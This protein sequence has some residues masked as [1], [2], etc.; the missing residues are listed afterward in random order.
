MALEDRYEFLETIG[1]GTF[2]T[3]YRARDLELGREVAVK[4]LHEQY[5][6]DPAALERYWQEAQLLASLQHPNIVTIY[7]IHRERGWLI[8]ELM[9]SSLAKRMEGRQMDLRAVRTTLAHCLR[10]LKYL[11]PRGIVHGDIKLGNL[12]IDH[13][14]RVKLGDFG[15]AYRVSDDDGSILKGTTRYMAPEVVSEEF[16]EIG[17]ASDL[18]SLGFCAWEL[19]CGPNFES[20]FPG[21]SAFGRNRQ[22]AWMMWHAAPDRRLPEIHRVLEGVPEDVATVVQKLCEKD[23]SRRYSSADDALS[24]LNIDLKVVRDGSDEEPAETDSDEEAARRKRLWLAGGGFAASFLLS[25]VLLLLPAGGDPGPPTDSNIR[26]GTVQAVYADENRL[27]VG[28]LEDGIPE[29][30]DLGQR[31][32]IFFRNTQEHILIRELQPGDRVEIDLTRDENGN[33]QVAGVT[34]SR[35][36]TSL[37]RIR[38]VDLDNE[39]ILVAVEQGETRDDLSLRVPD[40]AALHLNE[41][42]RRVPLRDL[43]EGDSVQVT[44]LHEAGGRA[45]RVVQELTVNRL[46]ERVGLV[47]EIDAG[48]RRMTVRFG[49]QTT[50]TALSLPVAA[51][52]EITLRDAGGD[53]GQRIEL[54]AIRPGDRVQFSS[55]TEFHRIVAIRDQRQISGMVE[56]VDS[57]KR[58]LLIREA[59]GRES[60]FRLAE[61]TERRGDVTLGDDTIGLADLRQYDT[62]HLTAGDGEPALVSSL[63]ATRPAR[64]DRWVILIANDQFAEK[65]VPPVPRAVE[66]ANALH[67]VL[68]GRY[69]VSESRLLYLKNRSRAEIQRAVS[70]L[71]ERVGRQTQLVVYVASPGYVDEEGHAFLAT[72]DFN[73]NRM[74]ETGLPLDWLAGEIGRADTPD[75]LLLLDACF[76][77]NS[78]DR[79]HQPSTAEMLSGLSSPLQA[80]VAIASCRQGERGLTTLQGRRGVF[81]RALE[82]GFSGPADTNRD[83]RMTGDELMTWL[84]EEMPRQAGDRQQLP[85]RFPRK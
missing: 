21:L 13:R 38:A 27:K 6:S 20:L 51:D 61:Q 44:H 67:D 57:G 79:Q 3:V 83:L 11:H 16:G 81:S 77:G 33:R 42:G 23:Q 2:A 76:D 53:S 68:R 1:S 35:P 72:R 28:G 52:A 17:P 30:F 80:T 55:D 73:W 48:R 58:E 37:G 60:L 4:Q 24:D 22:I 18:Y 78:P 47:R 36:V 7:D 65:F 15:L 40:S 75:R 14:R 5:L 32:K 45:G 10:A 70:E 26:Y 39:R 43:R 56:Q 82:A 31:P 12:M 71:V 84:R 46:I 62:V 34:V 54:N 64:A 59:N 85:E 29:E 8:M 69:A 9:Q 50:G 74:T 19:M 49:P 25:M 41:P 63:F 66:D